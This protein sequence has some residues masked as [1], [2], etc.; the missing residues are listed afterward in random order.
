MRES[1]QH[2][3]LSGFINSYTR[4]VCV[5]RA[6]KPTLLGLEHVLE[7]PFGSESGSRTTGMRENSEQL[8]RKGFRE[9]T[10]VWHHGATSRWIGRTHPY[11][12]PIP[13]PHAPRSCLLSFLSWLRFSLSAAALKGS[14]WQ[15]RFGVIFVI[16]S[17]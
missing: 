16:N 13:I 14:P 8:P 17:Q 7:P 15:N 3:R 10:G 5:P 6:P 4:R 2:P 1:C 12:I 11:T 9:I